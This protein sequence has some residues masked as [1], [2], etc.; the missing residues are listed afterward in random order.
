MELDVLNMGSWTDPMYDK[1]VQECKLCIS[2]IPS[3]M[4]YHDEH[5]IDASGGCAVYDQSW[6]Q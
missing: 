5:K 3:G 4:K 6:L 2:L 1:Q